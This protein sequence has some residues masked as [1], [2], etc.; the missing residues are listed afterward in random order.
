MEG[1]GVHTFRLVDERGTSRF[2]KFHWKPLLGV[3]SVL[4]DE[5]QKISGQGPGL[6]PARPLGGDRAAARSPSGSWACRSSRRRTSTRSSSTC[7]TRPRSSP[8]S[9]C[10]SSG[11][12]GWSS[13]ATPTTSSPRRSRSRSI[14]ATSCPAS[15]SPTTRSC[16]A[17]CSPTPTPSSFGSAGPTS[18]R[19]RS[20]GRWR[21][22]TT[23]SATGTCARRSTA[24]ESSYHPNSLGGGCP[25]QAGRR[26]RRLRHAT[27]SA[28]DAAKMRARGE[29]FFDHFSQATLFWNSQ[30]EPEKEHI[31]QAL[32]FE[33]GK[34]ESARR[35]AS[36]WW[37]CSPRSTRA[38]AGTGGRG[39]RASPCRREM[40][41]PLNHSVP[42]DGDPKEFQPR[43]FKQ[44][45][46]AIARR[47]AWPTPS[48]DTREDA[49]GRDP[50]RRRRRRR[51]GRA[52]C[53]AL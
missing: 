4:W 29:K 33:L 42:A 35:S 23:T 5:A 49:Q 48:K 1:F 51:R 52:A 38:L 13:T 36:G 11:S 40:D 10:R 3:H 9:S 37:A 22:S 17:G 8:R 28:I 18:T 27:P 26:P 7:S 45:I 20:T 30:S 50:G 21:R 43:R 39:P 25:M 41:G 19:S 46:D 32:R 34:V 53:S 2:V 16:R 44:R 31:V 14:P 24:A 12:A 6:P 15:I 47:S